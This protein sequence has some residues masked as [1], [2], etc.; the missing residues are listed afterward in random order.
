MEDCYDHELPPAPSIRRSFVPTHTSRDG[1][2]TDG[3]GRRLPQRWSNQEHTCD[4]VA[5]LPIHR[6][7]AD[8]RI[9]TIKDGWGRPVVEQF[10]PENLKHGTLTHDDRRVYSS[11]TIVPWPA[12]YFPPLSAYTPL[13]HINEDTQIE[14]QQPTHDRLVWADLDFAERPTQEPILNWDLCD[15]DQPDPVPCR[16][17]YNKCWSSVANGQICSASNQIHEGQ[18]YRNTLIYTYNFKGAMAPQWELRSVDV[19]IFAGARGSTTTPMSLPNSD[20]NGASD[21]VTLVLPGSALDDAT[22][23]S[24]VLDLGRYDD[25][26]LTRAYLPWYN[27]HCVSLEDDDG[28]AVNKPPGNCTDDGFNLK[29]DWINFDTFLEMVA[30]E[31]VGTISTQPKWCKWAEAHEARRAFLVTNES[32]VDEPWDGEYGPNSVPSRGLL[33]PSTTEDGHVLALHVGGSIRYSHSQAACSAR[34]FDKIQSISA[35]HNDNDLKA[36]S[37]EANY[38]FATEPLRWPDGETITPFKYVPGSYP[39]ISTGGEVIL[40]PMAN[41]QF[42]WKPNWVHSGLINYDN[43]TSPDPNT[44]RTEVSNEQLQRNTV[45]VVAAGSW[46]RGKIVHLDNMINYSNFQGPAYEREREIMNLP[47]YD[48]TDILVQPRGTSLLNSMENSLNHLEALVPIS[49]FDVVWLLSSS[50]HQ[51]AE[52]VFDDYMHPRAFVIGHMNEQITNFKTPFGVKVDDGFSAYIDDPLTD[53]DESY[54]FDHSPKL[55]NASTVPWPPEIKLL[56]GAFVPPIAEGGVVGKGV[57]LDGRNDHI[58]VGPLNFN[59][60]TGQ[61]NIPDFLVTLWLEAHELTD[62][63]RTLL[64]FADGA[65]ITLAND[66]LRYEDAND[67]AHAVFWPATSTAG[68]APRYT[69][70][71]FALFD[72]STGQRKLR[73]YLD[74]KSLGDQRIIDGVITPAARAPIT[75]LYVGTNV[76]RLVETSQTEIVAAPVRGWVDD[77]RVYGLERNTVSGHLEWDA[78]FFGEWVC[79]RALGSLRVA[80]VNGMQVDICDQLDFR[81]SDPQVAQNGWQYTSQANLPIGDGLDFAMDSYTT[82]SCANR[83]HRNKGNLN[84]VRADR[85][86]LPTLVHNS[87]RPDSTTEAF[88]QTCHLPTHPLAALG[89]LEELVAGAPGTTVETDVRRQPMMWPPHTGG[90]M[91]HVLGVPYGNLGTVYP[92]S[93]SDFQT[94]LDSLVL[95]YGR[96][97]PR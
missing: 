79:N 22:P 86:G 60:N 58:E 70:Y 84:C 51:T 4:K 37:G 42:G 3:V 46:T 62:D 33:E 63:P 29:A 91:P 97:P 66:G 10:F 94:S 48:D 34:G 13:A 72:D 89:G 31:C 25:W 77:L 76:L 49:P 35:A 16:I 59:V 55:Q 8:G 20:P 44:S 67:Q 45:S 11:G 52:L 92:Y 53:E 96:V 39:W 43:S 85:L 24:G 6:A 2:K 18:C 15:G 17:K 80:T 1:V 74:G 23:V 93:A 21:L 38:G 57:F 87:P 41:T 5:D 78:P 56:G 90:Y 40:W 32:G 36:P 65:V 95:Q 82:S 50:S 81:H 69:H 9:T 47:L 7:S 19:T 14:A 61:R 68:A 30:D 73:V 88:C 64:T 54:Q 75:S 26:D 71:A 28:V 83:A 12:R 27:D